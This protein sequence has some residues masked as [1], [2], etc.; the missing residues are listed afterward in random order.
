MKALLLPARHLMWIHRIAHALYGNKLTRPISYF[1]YLVARVIYASDVHP[2]ARIGKGSHFVHHFNIVIGST[3]VIGDNCT[4]FNG[5]TLGDNGKD[6]N[7]CP[8]IGDNVL[9]SAGSKVVGPVSVGSNS[10]VGANSVVIR[11]VPENSLAVGL[12]AVVKRTINRED[13]Y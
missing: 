13:Y 10:I 8:T 5:V 7:L 12:P 9:L 11:D 3:A 6:R 4:I 1:I 2:A